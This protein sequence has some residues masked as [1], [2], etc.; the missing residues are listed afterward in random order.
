MPTRKYHIG[1]LCTS[2]SL[3]GLELNAFRMACWLQERNWKVTLFA[4]AGS[5]LADSAKKKHLDVVAANRTFKYANFLSAWKLYL[6]LKKRKIHVLYVADNKDI[7]LSVNAKIYSFGKV[8]ILY[9]QQMQIGI[10]KKDLL[11]TLRYSYLDSWL[12]PLVWL[13]EEVKDKTRVPAGRIHIVPLG[14]EL[15]PFVNLTSTKKEARHQLNL[16]EDPF[17][18]GCI[19]R[20]DPGKG[21]EMLVRAL[22]QLRNGGLSIELV[23]VGDQTKNEGDIYYNR[24]MQL[25]RDSGLTR[26]VHFRPFSNEVGTYMRSLDVFAMASLKET[27]GMVTLE[28]MAT[29]VPVIGTNTGGTPEILEHGELGYLFTPGN[30]EG[31]CSIIQHILKFPGEAQLKAGEALKHVKEHF[32]HTAECELLEG[33]I[34]EVLG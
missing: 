12:S 1:V 34:E 27:Y 18:I 26:Y 5:P 14:L 9:H 13:A 8:R 19:G 16:P 4:A 7:S 24:V 31:F 17:L 11:H 33:I 30:V 6:G 28:A 10:N 15:G 25:I 21:Q 23:I 29:G 2:K 32:S 3:G 20:I 22:V